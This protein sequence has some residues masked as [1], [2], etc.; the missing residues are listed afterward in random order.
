MNKLMMQVGGVVAAVTI[1]ALLA[2]VG[3]LT[4]IGL[5]QTFGPSAPAS[6]APPRKQPNRNRAYS[7]WV[8]SN[9]PEEER[10]PIPEGE[11][12]WQDYPEED[13][14][15][16][17]RLPN[18]PGNFEVLA[19]VARFLEGQYA[20]EPDYPD[21]AFPCW[22]HAKKY[23]SVED[24][25]KY[26]EKLEA[27]DRERGEHRTNTLRQYNVELVMMSFVNIA[28]GSTELPNFASYGMSQTDLD[29]FVEMR[30]AHKERC[31]LVLVTADLESLQSQKVE[32]ITVKDPLK[33]FFV[34]KPDGWKLT[35]IED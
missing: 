23:D 18:R 5:T 32:S 17:P 24:F 27:K 7:N 19:A 33:L 4:Q 6:N 2:G 11:S 15:Y 21:L 20:V 1:F 28:A 26:W 9:Q 22:D 8:D 35:C 10:E 30:V 25:E 12:V 31:V 29:R 16:E 34:R 14:D 13:L 3:Y